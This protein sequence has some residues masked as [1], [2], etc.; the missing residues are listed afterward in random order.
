MP[1][2]LDLHKIVADINIHRKRFEA[3]D[4]RF[5]SLEA[6]ELG[7][8]VVARRAGLPLPVPTPMIVWQGWSSFASAGGII[9]YSFGV[10][11]PSTTDEIWLFAHAFVGPANFIAD[12]GA[13]V[14]AVDPRFSRLTQPAF[15]GLQIAPGAT[16]SLSFQ[17]QIPLGMEPSNYLGNTFLFRADWHDV[18]A[19]LDRGCWPFGVNPPQ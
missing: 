1:T 7:A 9:D 15:P 10:L 11:N 4:K 5:T 13:A 3:P 18:G 16:A 2:T 14:Q 19:Y 8:R 17:M 6:S 12:P